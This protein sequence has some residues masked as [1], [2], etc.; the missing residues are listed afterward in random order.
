[1][2][3]R[4]AAPLPPEIRRKI[5]RIHITTRVA[6]NSLLAGEYQSAIKGRGMNFD[7]YREYQPGD[8]VRTI[9]WNVTARLA[10]PYVKLFVEERE[11]TVVFLVDS[12]G[13]QHFGSQTVTKHELATEVCAVLAF[14]AVE[15]N[16]KVGLILFAEEIEKVVPPRKGERHVL[17]VVRDLL[18][19]RPTRRRTNLVLALQELE[20]RVHKKSLVFVVSDFLDEGFMRPLRVAAQKHDLVAL[21]VHDPRELEIPRIGFLELEDAETGEVVLVDSSNVT[22]Q[23]FFR[24]VTSEDLEHR[25]RLLRATGAEVIELR[26]DRPYLDPLV[27]FF[28]T[29]RMRR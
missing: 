2:M 1:M 7:E 5:R 12:S 28:R 27:R 14:S 13:S 9:D 29:R 16:D 3:Q 6:V 22:F 8:E 24:K 19:S 11:L 21:L 20:R 4:A 15:N 26:T 10:K 25:R 18:V 17:R 23:Q